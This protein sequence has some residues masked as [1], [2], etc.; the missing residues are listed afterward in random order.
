MQNEFENSIINKISWPEKFVKK[1]KKK[2]KYMNTALILKE[3][4]EPLQESELD[5]FIQY[6]F[7]KVRM[8]TISCSNDSFAIKLFQVLNTRGM[9]LS[10]SDLIKSFLL[11][12][13]DADKH[14]QFMATWRD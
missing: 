13:L 7:N 11:S 4:I 1:D 5:S 8:I 6:L 12:K 3:K 2:Y 10:P 14:D 9:D